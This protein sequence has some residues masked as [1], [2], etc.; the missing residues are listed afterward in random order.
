M[1][2]VELDNLVLHGSAVQHREL[3]NHESKLFLSYF[4]D[5]LR[6]VHALC[7]HYVIETS[8]VDLWR[9]DV[10]LYMYFRYLDGGT[11]SGFFHVD[12]T[13]YVKRLFQVKGKK[14]IRIEQVRN[15]SHDLEN[16]VKLWPRYYSWFVYVLKVE[17]NSG[18]LNQSDTFVLDD[19][20]NIFV[21]V[22][23]KSE[24]KEQLG[25]RNKYKAYMYFTCTSTCTDCRCHVACS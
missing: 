4:K 10:L 13:V 19:G 21:W 6:C 7:L 18:S 2:A 14:R 24:K 22:G 25:V 12:P 11:E 1:R 9:H 3:Q 16:E 15:Q 20:P 5:D 23:P 8:R 17:V